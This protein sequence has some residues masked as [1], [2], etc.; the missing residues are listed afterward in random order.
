METSVNSEVTAASHEDVV[1]VQTD[2]DMRNKIAPMER[3]DGEAMSK[4]PDTFPGLEDENSTRK[5]EVKLSNVMEDRENVGNG[6][7][8]K[9]GGSIATKKDEN[10]SPR[11]NVFN[12]STAIEFENVEKTVN[13]PQEVESKHNEIIQADVL[14]MKESRDGETASSEPKGLDPSA[15]NT[16]DNAVNKRT[17]EGSAV[18]KFIIH[19]KFSYIIYS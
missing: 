18:G 14:N 10:I 19:Y 12:N 7:E 8:N 15:V 5:E 13:S 4:E 3:E 1:D 17:C 6:G 16:L 2:C 9:V 11:L